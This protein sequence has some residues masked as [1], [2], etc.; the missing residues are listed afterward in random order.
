MNEGFYSIE[1]AKLKTLAEIHNRLAEISQYLE[2]AVT[3][4]AK[5]DVKDKESDE[6]VRLLNLITIE[7]NYFIHNDKNQFVKKDCE[8]DECLYKFYSSDDSVL[9]YKDTYKGLYTRTECDSVE[10]IERDSVFGDYDR[11]INYD[12][13]TGCI[14]EFPKNAESKTD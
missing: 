2:I 13:K 12:T 3:K 9:G 14:K 4:Y 6:W 7:D 5:I 10:H 11:D 1:K 8:D